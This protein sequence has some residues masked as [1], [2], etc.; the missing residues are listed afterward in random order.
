MPLCLLLIVLMLADVACADDATRP[1]EGGDAFGSEREI[2]DAGAV[3]LLID[4]RGG[5][6]RSSA[7]L[8]SVASFPA[9]SPNEYLVSAGLWIGGIKNGQ[10]V[11]A[12]TAER[13]PAPSEFLPGRRSG[14]GTGDTG[15]LC[16]SRPADLERWYPEFRDGAGAPLLIGDEDCIA[17]FHDGPGIHDVETPIGIEVRQRV[18]SFRTGLEAQTVL[19]VWDFDIAG[20][21]PLTDAH[22]AVFVDP[23]IGADFWDDRCSAILEVQPGTNNAA[24]TAVA[25]NLLFCWDHDF[26]E[27]NF[28]PNLPGF[29][30]VSFLRAPGEPGPRVLRRATQMGNT[31]TGPLPF[32][33]IH[34]EGQYALLVGE[35]TS[36]PILVSD[37]R[38]VRNLAIAGPFTLVPGDA[39]QAVAAFIWA[40][41]ATPVTSLA[42]SAERCFPE[43][44]P[45]FLPDPNDPALAELVAVQQAV[46]ERIG[47]RLPPP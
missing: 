47:G 21:E 15:I 35:F 7:D 25:A 11:V 1:A 37:P 26:D 2:L 30:G 27:P 29:F 28:N 39:R 5:I 19:F 8:E 46:Q 12:A 17:I 45:C 24:A 14:Q 18:V 16:S 20:S 33:P 41:A 36:S 4:N 38:D 43:G 32:D 9:G 3:R 6:A 31:F 42:V 22:V 10:S 40:N 34:D 13:G 23:D 44:R